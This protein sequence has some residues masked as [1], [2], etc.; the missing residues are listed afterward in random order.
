MRYIIIIGAFLTTLPCNGQSFTKIYASGSALLQH[1]DLA[2]ASTGGWYASGIGRDTTEYYAFLSKFDVDGNLLWSKKPDETRDARAL[3]AL[4]DGSVLMF[5]NNS[6][7]QGY[8]DASMLHVGANGGFISETIWGTPNDQDD[9]FDAKKMSDGRIVAIGMSREE[10]SFSERILLA[11]FT[12][13]AQVVWEKTYDGGIFGRFS[14]ILPLPTGGFYALGQSFSAGSFVGLLGKFNEEGDLQWVKS[15]DYGATATYFLAGQAFA[16]GSVLVA[17]YQTNQNGEAVQLTLVNIS[18]TG[19][20]TNQTTLEGTYGL[21]PFAMEML[22]SDTIVM[23]A[24]SSGQ[25]F[26]VI[27]NDNVIVQVSPQGDL[28]GSLAFGTEG[29]EFGTDA[30]LKGRQVV[31][32]GM[33]DASA[34]GTAR[35]AYISKSGI[36]ASCCAKDIEIQVVASPPLPT[37]VDLPFSSSTIPV[38]QNH[39]VALSDFLLSESVSCQNPDGAMLLA[40]DTTICTGDTLSLSVVPNIPGGILWNTGATSREISVTAPGAYTVVLSGECGEAKD[41]IQVLAIGNSVTAQVGLASDVCPGEQVSLTASGGS[42]FLWF[43]ADGFPV[44]A[45]PNP[46]ATLFESTTYQVVVSDGQCRDTASVS[47]NVL[48]APLVS[49]GADRSIPLGV[50]I[51]LAAAGA[52]TYNWSPRAGLSCADCPEPLASPDSTTTYTVIGTDTNGCSDT[53]S[54]TVFVE[55]PC[56]YYI[57]NVFSPGSNTGSDNRVFGVYSPE[58]ETSGFQLR[59][60]SR[61][62]E[63]VFASENPQTQWNGEFNNKP[64]P[65]GV[66]IYQLQMNTC[67]GLIKTG[68][69][70]TLIR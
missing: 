33:T 45:V 64:V 44:F 58:I 24:V 63:L 66:Y 57:P 34:D 2:T 18:A 68:G 30:F 5:N 59:I 23:A 52:E 29:Q 60:Y 61:W 17:A 13:D 54:V 62:G 9:W 70:L 14:K 4:D 25:V 11:E 43:D 22:H 12:P 26:P 53:T 3:V 37:I 27:D 67:Q 42:A 19:A 41:T 32:C 8:F 50:Q 1:S 47:V 49:A 51:S 15:Y 28:L 20:V 16:D 40:T 21:G 55:Q 56:P 7:F 48:P 6:G 39:V 46:V 10:F 38:K 69:D 36:N 65:A 35:R 31:T